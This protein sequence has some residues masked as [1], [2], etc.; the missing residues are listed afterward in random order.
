VYIRSKDWFGLDHVDVD[1]TL[2]FLPS[3]CSMQ[4][5]KE[6]REREGRRG[7]EMVLVFNL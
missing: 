4:R 5:E 3:R 7:I 1:R 2:V 6:G